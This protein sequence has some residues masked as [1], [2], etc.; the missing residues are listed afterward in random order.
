MF[1]DIATMD[2]IHQRQLEMWDVLSALLE[3]MEIPYFFVHGS[4]LGAVTRG[5]FIDEDDD[6]DIAIFR[7]DY[8]RL[9]HEGNRHLPKRYMVQSCINDDFPLSFGKFRDSESAFLQPV[10]GGYRCNKGLYIDIFPIDYLPSEQAQATFHRQEM[11]LSARLCSRMPAQGWKTRVIRTAAR[12]YAPSFSAAARRLDRLMADLPESNRLRLTNGKAMEQSI[13]GAW[14]QETVLF[15]FCGRKV[16][17]PGGYGDY[18]AAIYGDAYL[19]YNPAESR[20]D[21]AGD[22]EISADVLDLDR[23]YR[24]YCPGR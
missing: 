16:Q 22:V 19:N 1:I 10:L 8:E 9:I 5:G 4:L 11:L 7:A 14:F 12:L 24:E 15:D 21:Q 23:S 2:R 20:I 13:P 18:L 17:C 6:I 3:Q